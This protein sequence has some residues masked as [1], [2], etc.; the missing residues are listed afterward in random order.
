MVSSDSGGRCRRA[1]CVTK[2]W[3]P[4]REQV[5]LSDQKKGTYAKCLK[6]GILA[7][8]V[9]L[10]ASTTWTEMRA[11]DSRLCLTPLL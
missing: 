7:F 5:R 2:P 4:G 6:G 1:R 10:P 8:R 11:G 3:C 9:G